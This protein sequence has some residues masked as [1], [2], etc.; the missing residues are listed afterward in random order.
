MATLKVE[1]LREGVIK[2]PYFNIPR[3]PLSATNNNIFRD[4][5]ISIPLALNGKLWS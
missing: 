3:K 2:S 1:L 4:Y 5:F